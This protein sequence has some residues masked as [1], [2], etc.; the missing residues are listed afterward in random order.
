VP[1]PDAADLE[2]LDALNIALM[3]GSAALACVVPFEMFLV[4]YA[5][6]G[7]L[8]YL[9]QISW[10]GDRRC[11]TTAPLDWVPLALLALLALDA[12][13]TRW[14]PWRGAAFVALV[15]G[16]VSAFAR[17]ALPKLA[18]FVAAAALAGAVHAWEPADV[19]FAGLLPTV[20]HVYAGTGLFLVAGALRRRSGPGWA[21]VAVFAACGAGLLLVRPAGGAPGAWALDRLAPFDGLLYAVSRVAGEGPDALM[22]IGRF[23]AFAYTYHYLNWFSKTRLIGWHTVSRRR[24]VA[25]VLLWLASVA[26][27]AWDYASG[28]LLL[29]A[30]SMAHVFLEFPLDARTALA[31]ARGLRRPR[32]AQG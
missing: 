27:Y 23:L 19:L 1:A 30:L 22:A 6:L 7:P 13:S 18:A 11:F 14:V 4:A 15:G 29:F 2:R 16:S 26:L 12:V 3:L 24:G 21:S 32:A 8:H 25:I 17:G 31:V 5:L 9:T 20:L 28:L 10:L